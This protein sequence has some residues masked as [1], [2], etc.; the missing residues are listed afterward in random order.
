[1]KNIDDIKMYLEELHPLLSCDNVVGEEEA[2][3]RAGKFLEVQ[4]Q[5]GVTTHALTSELF[6]LRSLDACIYAKLINA[7]PAKNVTEK[8]LNA[9]AHSD[10]QP[11]HERIEQIESDLNYLKTMAHVFDG[12]HVFYRQHSKTDRRGD[13]N[14]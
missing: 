12:G 3:I 4:Y 6:K 13:F 2:K 9:E 10:Y 8:K 5:I 7:D 14:G 11:T 1:M